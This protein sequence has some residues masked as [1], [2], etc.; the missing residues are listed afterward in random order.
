LGTT[1]T[2]RNFDLSQTHYRM[3]ADYL[4]KRKPL[5]ARR[6]LR[7]ALKLDPENREA[8]HL[9]GILMFVEGMH[10]LNLVD[11]TQCLRGSE[12]DEQRAVANIEFRKAEGYLKTSVKMAKEVEE[13]IQSEGLVYLANIALHFKRYKEAVSLSDQAMVNDLYGGKHLAQAVKGWALYKQRKLKAAAREF[14]QVIYERPNFCLGLYRLA[15]VY[16]DQKLYNRSITELNKVMKIKECPIQEVPHLL[17][18]SY[19]RAGSGRE[20]VREQ[21]DICAKMNPKSC[22][23]RECARLLK[24]VAPAMEEAVEAA[25]AEEAKE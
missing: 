20:K 18:L 19:T 2:K 24:N 16:H 14:R 8:H 22:L 21:F 25:P 10:K 9:L 3:G 11:R 7:K 15:K 6:E 1:A 17:G 13:K 4:S 5:A 23:S 12:A